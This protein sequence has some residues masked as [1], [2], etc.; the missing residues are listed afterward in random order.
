VATSDRPAAES[1][2]SVRVLVQVGDATVAAVEVVG[3]TVVTRAV[4]GA[5]T[6]RLA[7]GRAA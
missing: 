1:E 5:V 2:T 6:I 4:D 7:P 3:E